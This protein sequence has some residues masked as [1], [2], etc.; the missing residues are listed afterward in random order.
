MYEALRKGA[1]VDELCDI[2]KIKKYFV[3]QMKELVDE[4]ENL[5]T[6]KGSVPAKRRIEAG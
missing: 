4:E 1:T 2:T 5:L 6:M 3:E